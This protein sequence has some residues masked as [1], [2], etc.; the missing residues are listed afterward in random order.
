[1]KTSFEELY[2]SREIRKTAKAPPPQQ[3]VKRSR[4]QGNFRK[5]LSVMWELEWI[6]W[7]AEN[8]QTMFTLLQK[9][10]LYI[11]CAWKMIGDIMLLE[12]II[13]L[14]SKW[15]LLSSVL[16]I[17]DH[18]QEVQKAKSSFEFACLPKT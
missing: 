2:L 10:N 6:S 3:E 16:L 4:E 11:N 8:L 17:R 12:S 5:L 9:Q 7:P 1:M 14:I 18:S 13:N 15:T